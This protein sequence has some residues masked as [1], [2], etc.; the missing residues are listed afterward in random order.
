MPHALL[1]SG[2]L[3]QGHDVM[4]AACAD[5]LHDR[6]WT[7][8][9]VDAMAL[10]GKTGGALG[11]ALFRR[12]LA[13]PGVYDAFHFSALRPG[14]RVALLGERAAVARLAPRVRELL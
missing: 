8:T 7:T 3:G 6:G 5:S 2:S 12:M 13:L 1:L 4:A 10:L 14:A 9:T 11:E